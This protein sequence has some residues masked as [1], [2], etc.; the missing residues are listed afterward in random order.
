MPLGLR[1]ML[2][3]VAGRVPL[4]IEL[5]GIPGRDAGLVAAVARELLKPYKG[6]A[7]IM[8]FDHW[9]IRDFRRTRRRAFRAGSPPGVRKNTSGRRISRC[10]PTSSTSCPTPHRAPAE[11]FISFV[12]ERLG[13]PVITWTV[14]DELAW[15]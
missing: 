2:E 14:R 13:M 1:E 4:V 8:S 3:L 5:K 12:R 7:A 6:K 15:A 11:P 10:W 9:L